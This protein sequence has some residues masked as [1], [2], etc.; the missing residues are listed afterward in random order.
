VSVKKKRIKSFV[1]GK[2]ES[3]SIRTELA[4]DYRD[5]SMNIDRGN[6]GHEL[7]LHRT[8]FSENVIYEYCINSKVEL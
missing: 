1:Q 8:L 4:A 2:I 7:I 5:R 3:F 6:A